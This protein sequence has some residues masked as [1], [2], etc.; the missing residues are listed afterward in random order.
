MPTKKKTKSSGKHP[1][2]SDVDLSSR[3]DTTEA[4]TQRL[5]KLQLQLLSLQQRYVHEGRRAIIVFEGWDAAGKGGI[6]RRINERLDPRHC[7]VWSIA[8]P[9]PD[10]QGRHYM[11]RF[12]KRLPLKGDIAI[13]DRSWYGRVLVERVE[14]F[15]KPDAWQRAYEEINEFERTLTDDGVRIVKLFLHVSADEQLNRFAERL[16]K[17][18]K[19]WKLTFE[20][21]RNR[22]KRA[23]YE[24]AIADMFAKTDTKVAPWHVISSEHK[25]FGRLAAIETIVK[26]LGKDVATTPPDISPEVE[27]LLYARLG[28]KP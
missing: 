18:Y 17:P 1:S 19:R 24:A 14:G 28:L 27:R 15:A 13:F 4:Y 23:D 12:W 8:A 20:D 6:I 21:I 7:Y 22:D 16:R 25:L 2:L 26:I 3:V 9:N 11:Y 10:D 5:G